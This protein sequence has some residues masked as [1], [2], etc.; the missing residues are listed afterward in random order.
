MTPGLLDRR[1]IN[2]ESGG[3]LDEQSSQNIS[4]HLQPGCLEIQQARIRASDSEEA[5]C[6]TE[7]DEQ[8]RMRSESWDL[9]L[10]IAWKRFVHPSVELPMSAPM[11]HPPSTSWS[12]SISR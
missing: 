9:G 6:G 8:Q 4:T 10:S 2:L 11:L 12:M 1:E 7:E 5:G 3:I